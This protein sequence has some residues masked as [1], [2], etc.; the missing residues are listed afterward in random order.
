MFPKKSKRPNRVIMPSKIKRG[1]AKPKSATP[2]P[3][4]VRPKSVGW[5]LPTISY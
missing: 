2:K 3:E 4:N 5:A 1:G